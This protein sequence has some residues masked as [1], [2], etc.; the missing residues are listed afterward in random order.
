MSYPN[1]EPQVR[2]NNRAM[3]GVI[4]TI[5]ALHPIFARITEQNPTEQLIKRL[6]FVHFPE[7]KTSGRES[8]SNS[9]VTWLA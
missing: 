7:T 8:L 2:N 3:H 5:Y 4:H 6:S 9:I 1:T